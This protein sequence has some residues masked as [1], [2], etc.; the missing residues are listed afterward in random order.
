M[1]QGHLYVMQLRP[2]ATDTHDDAH[3]VVS[4]VDFC[5]TSALLGTAWAV[6]PKNLNINELIVL[7]VQR[8]IK[9]YDTQA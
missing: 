5:S 2:C 3:P 6:L 9:V 8:K 7:R 4:T 1:V